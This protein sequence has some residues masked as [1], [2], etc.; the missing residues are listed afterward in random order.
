LF[1]FYFYLSARYV[2]RKLNLAGRDEAEQAEVDMW[3]DQ[4]KDFLEEL[5]KA[6]FEPER[7]FKGREV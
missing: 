6:S 2:A 4:A 7:G 1:K 5:I 3:A